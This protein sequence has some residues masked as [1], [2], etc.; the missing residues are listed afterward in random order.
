MCLVPNHAH[1]TCTCTVQS[2]KNANKEM[3]L[4]VNSQQHL[5]VKELLANYHMY[6]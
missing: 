4:G 6:R 1:C 3:A 2:A 5:L